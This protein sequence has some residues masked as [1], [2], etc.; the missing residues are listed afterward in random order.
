MHPHK[1]RFVT[2]AGKNGTYERF[3]K[4]LFKPVCHTCFPPHK[5][6]PSTFIRRNSNA[7][8]Q[9]RGVT[10]RVIFQFRTTNFRALST[11]PVNNFYHC[12]VNCKRTGF[13]VYL[14][15][16]YF[17]FLPSARAVVLDA[18]IQAWSWNLQKGFSRSI[19]QI[20]CMP[21]NSLLIS[22]K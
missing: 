14:F 2:E 15:L 16:F 19:W 1:Y 4:N 21:I 13:R 11:P 5:I 17:I 18:R 22:R 9:W 6:F 3:A 10:S 8:D 12:T 7:R 20:R